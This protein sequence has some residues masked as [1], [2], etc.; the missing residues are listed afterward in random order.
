M[1]LAGAGAVDGDFAGGVQAGSGRAVEIAAFDLDDARLVDRNRRIRRGEIEFDAIRLEIL[2]QERFF[3]QRLA[4]GI[5]VDA[6]GP[7][8]GHRVAGNGEGKR[9]AAAFGAC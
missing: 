8:S 1:R 7:G 4:L 9:V 5:C 3:R 2:D 6:R